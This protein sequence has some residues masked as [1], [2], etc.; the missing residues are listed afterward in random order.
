MSDA[1]QVAVQE[2]VLPIWQ[3]IF[4]NPNF[5]NYAQIAFG[6]RFNQSKINALEGSA[7]GSDLGVLP[8]FQLLS[9]EVMGNAKGAFS[10]QTHSI[11]LNRDFVT[12]NLD[13]PSAVADVVVEELGHSIDSVFGAGDAQGDEGEILAKL[14]RNGVIDPSTLQALKAE[15][16]SA[17]IIINGQQIAIEQAK[18]DGY[19]WADT[20]IPHSAP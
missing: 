7:N 5:S 6:D 1:S 2:A 11:Y 4:S 15:D 19:F 14:T 12:Q 3:G 16:D 9:G 8:D 17:T 18:I 20:L 13:N 10:A